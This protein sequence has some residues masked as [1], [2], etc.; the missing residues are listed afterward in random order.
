[1]LSTSCA[2]L[3]SV[4]CV[5]G[6]GDSRPNLHFFQYI[7]VYKPYT[8]SV[9]TNRV[10][11]STLG[12]VSLIMNHAQYTWSC[13]CDVSS[14]SMSHCIVASLGQKGKK[15]S[16]SGKVNAFHAVHVLDSTN[17]IL[18]LTPIFRIC[19]SHKL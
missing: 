19:F 17:S 2:A 14:P 7:Q 15:M 3:Y 10:T 1:M 11:H 16:A 5:L 13:S 12:L 18:K 8:D 6:I 9:P 4:V